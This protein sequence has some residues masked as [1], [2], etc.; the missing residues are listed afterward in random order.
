MI[1]A[2]VFLVLCFGPEHESYVPPKRRLTFS[3]LPDH[4]TEITRFT[5]DSLTT[6]CENQR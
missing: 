2:G 5:E 3:G 1:H 4:P 6:C